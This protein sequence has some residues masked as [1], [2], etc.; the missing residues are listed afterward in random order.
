MTGTSSI[1]GLG[2]LIGPPIFLA[3]VDAVPH[4]PTWVENASPLAILGFMVWFITTQVSTGIKELTI[5]VNGLKEEQAKNRTFME[6]RLE[7]I[8]R[9][10]EK[11]LQ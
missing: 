4:I 7:D 6:T 3:V 8:S 1:A 11:Q 9:F 10:M 2:A 5:A